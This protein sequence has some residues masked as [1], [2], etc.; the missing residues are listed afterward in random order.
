MRKIYKLLWLLCFLTLSSSVAFCQINGAIET[1]A[2]STQCYAYVGPS[3]GTAGYCWT[4]Q[5]G[6]ITNSPNC[7]PG[8]GDQMVRPLTG[9]GC[10]GAKSI[11]IHFTSVTT[12]TTSIVRVNDN[13]SNIFTRTVTIVPA[14]S[15]TGVSVSPSS[16]NI[17]INTAP[18]TM[19]VVGTPTKGDNTYAYQWQSSTD[20]VNFSNT[21]G[22][23]TSY[24]PG[25]ISVI[26]YYRVAVSSFDYVSYT[27]SVKVSVFPPVNAGTITPTPLNVNYGTS[28]TTLTLG[29]VSGGT[30]TY[31]YQWQN[32]N[33]GNTWTN[34]GG[35]TLTFTTPAL[36]L[37]TYYRVIVTSA[38][39]A[40][41]AIATINVNIQP[42]SITPTTYTVPFNGTPGAFTV[43]S[44]TGGTG[45][46]TY[47]WQNSLDGIN[48]TL[49][50]GAVSAG[51]TPPSLTNT[52][53]YE[54]IVYSNGFNATTSA[55]TVNVTPLSYGVLAPSNLT[56]NSNTN[57]NWAMTTT[58][59]QTGAIVGQEKK[60]FN[61]MGKNI[62]TQDKVFYR[63][64]ASTV[65]TH[66]L[67]T[68][69][70]RDAYGRYVLATMPAPI[71]YADF[72]YISGFVLAPDGS[73]YTYKNFDRFN[74]SGT[75]SDK[76]I[77]P[78]SLGG[79]SIAG[80]L[81][82]YYGSYNVWEPYSP[83]S[84]YP[85]TRSSVYKDGTN[86]KKKSAGAGEGLIMGSNHER[87]DFVMP[88]VGESAHYLQV[89]NKFFTTTQ[90]GNLP[91]NLINSLVVEVS[92]D[93]NGNE[94]FSMSDID[95][96][97]LMTA[98]P[99][100]DMTLN[101]STV[102]SAP[103]QN[104]NATVQGTDHL[105]IQPATTQITVMVG[106]TQFYSGPANG[107]NITTLGA[108]S[109]I[110][111]SAQGFSY[112]NCPN[113]TCLPV[114]YGTTPSSV[115]YFKILSDVTTVNIS[116][117]TYTLYDMNTELP[118]SLING[119]SLNRGFYR[120]VALTGTITINY[121]NSFSNITY[122][123]YNQLGQLVASIPPNGVK[124]IVGTGINNY[125]NLGSIPYISLYTYN[126]L[127]KQTN[128]S[129]ADAGI[130]S[131]VYRMDGKL[132]FSQNSFQNQCGSFSFINYDMYGRV[133]ETG[134]YLPD[135]NGIVFNSAAMSG[136]L[137]NVN[138]EGGLTTG[139]KT[140]VVYSVY[141][142]PDNSHGQAGYTQ[143]PAYLGGVISTTMKY[144]SIVNNAPLAANLVS[145][146]W[147]NYDEEGKVIWQ[148]KYIA[149]LGSAGYK[150]YDFTFDAMNRLTKKIFQKNTPSETFVHYFQYDPST[151][152]LWKVYT[153][154]VDNTSTWTLHANYI[155]YL[156][157]P[158]KRIELGTN[159][160]GI[161]YTY[162][163]KGALKA[164]NNGNK[165]ADPGGDG[166]ANGFSSDAY[167]M[168]LDYYNN[169]YLN[170]R[171]SIQP[172]NGVNTNGI[173]TDS[174]EGNIKAMTWYSEKPTLP[175]LTDAASTYVY[176]YDSKYQFS[177]STWGTNLSFSNTQGVPAGFT[178]PAPDPNQESIVLPGTSTPSYDENGNILNLQ[179]T[180]NSAVT[181]DQFVY[182]YVANTNKLASVTNNAPPTPGITYASYAYDPLGREMS[183]NL[184]SPSLNK[185]IQ[186]D[187]AGRTKL[188]ARDAAFTQPVV[189]YIYDE[190]GNRIE[191][192]S[193]NSSYQLDQVTYYYDDVIYSQP[194]TNGVYGTLLP[195]EYQIK[196]NVSRLGVYYKQAN[197]YAYELSDHLGNVR[198]VI[199]KNASTY[200][201]RLFNDYYPYGMILQNGGT[202]DYRYDYQGSYSEKDGE[203]G[204]NAFKL[205]NFN[206][207]IGRWNSVDPFG[208]FSSSYEGM[209]NNPVSQVDKNGGFIQELMNLFSHGM[210][211]SNDGYSA[212]QSL[213]AA[214]DDPSYSWTGGGMNGH[215]TLKWNSTD[216]ANS[217][218]VIARTYKPIEDLPT[219]MVGSQMYTAFPD[220]KFKVTAG[221]Q[222]GLEVGRT[223]FNV[224]IFSIELFNYSFAFGS[225]SIV[226][227][228]KNSDNFRFE[229]GLEG[230][231]T[232]P[233]TN[234]GIGG[235]I[236]TE[237]NM[238]LTDV[239]TS[240]NVK[241]GAF[242]MGAVMKGME[243]QISS[244]IGFFMPTPQLGEKVTFGVG[245]DLN[246]GIDVVPVA[247]ND[248]HA[249]MKTGGN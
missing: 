186:Y 209:G 241:L 119:N 141:D 161:D 46:Y 97:V 20:N 1:D 206:T 63:K 150:T 146:T 159:L 212:Y 115:H 35:T 151:G 71:N 140:D 87:S 120:V 213:Q 98:T 162:T 167:G 143:D 202:N 172:I 89:R 121:T 104:Y 66:V 7:V 11:T 8:G 214:G 165:N 62:Q 92:K 179:R 78:D 248:I 153:N 196:G 24:T 15:I 142:I 130:G 117:G 82:W 30:G 34:S 90:I 33:D 72:N 45:N 53:Y 234:I 171:S 114:N 139:T 10:S 99:G 201:V 85:Y 215:G 91:A 48:F 59:D 60:F 228:F 225:R 39:S 31:T 122:K 189:Q 217:V 2:G 94:L 123:Y 173:A 64:D 17:T 185:Y 227:G 116:G 108:Q 222:A 3:C 190:A 235:E 145:Q 208:Q 67:A 127:G 246:F 176:N 105:F 237:Y 156:H 149:S 111:S 79:Q 210:F 68:Q 26:T 216:L 86:N 83:T 110:V 193:Y 118:I 107:F 50:T 126:T 16:Q 129:T 88:E 18:A 57:M 93:P 211:I 243:N 22:T 195:Q 184:G 95:G 247:N 138:P 174:Y 74:P 183:E 200:T 158:L 249:F 28:G 12:L 5:N 113:G 65:Y 205:R 152:N 229:Q 124:L 132:R 47:Q 137:E 100:S 233:G 76:T 197:V 155:Y 77:N 177:N 51:F 96:K 218:Y 219:F 148:I 80:T 36:Y 160:Q 242:Q 198:A 41:S 157:G 203:T 106:S 38:G 14:L 224:D 27:P 144:S 131:L 29:N 125:S 61:Q 81:G 52:T 154:T 169:D 182:N 133:V 42:G 9:G 238:Q 44:P 75:E 192:L 21:S 226:D 4:S 73:N 191:K 58:Y 135:V 207:R 245:L 178:A 244:N 170:T 147:Y 188:I 223:G 23:G 164:I 163:L 19:T 69:S 84:Y 25:P 70:I 109:A 102:I 175:G 101:L 166:G 204:W 6:T 40:N 37:T 220:L 240:L 134:Q 239:V 55:A 56:G 180:N 230:K 181:T 43:S 231:I 32:S 232:I 112:Q 187:I 221:L 194:V 128:I 168:V 49:I 13:C 103:G 136:I 199:A 236:K 54:R